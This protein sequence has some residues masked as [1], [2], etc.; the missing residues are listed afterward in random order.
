MMTGEESCYMLTDDHNQNKVAKG[1]K[2][3]IVCRLCVSLSRN[4]W[5]SRNYTEIR[6]F[7][8]SM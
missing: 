7:W 5:I 2:Y 8:M 1:L 6:S 3:Y 4:R